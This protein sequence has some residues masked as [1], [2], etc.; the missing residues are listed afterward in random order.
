M[1]TRLPERSKLQTKSRHNAPNI[2][3]GGETL[4]RY[5]AAVVNVLSL[6]G[7]RFFGA[8]LD[9]ALHLLFDHS[10][11][12]AWD[13]VRMLLWR[14]GILSANVT[15]KKSMTTVAKVPLCPLMWHCAASELGRS[16]PPQALGAPG[17]MSIYLSIYLYL[18]LSLSLCMYV[19]IYIYI[20]L[21]MCLG[22]FAEPG[23]VISVTVI[24]ITSSISWHRFYHHEYCN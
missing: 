11:N 7:T 21:S 14:Y 4:E 2:I 18:S 16:A 15:L 9:Q 13:R 3:L 24:M 19:Y 17:A 1:K 23:R 6:Q 5:L 10:H 12:R 8:A 20:C 22:L